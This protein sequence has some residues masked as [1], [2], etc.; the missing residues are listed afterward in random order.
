[1][2][3]FSNVA[4]LYPNF[5][6]SKVIRVA[7]KIYTVSLHHKFLIY[8]IMLNLFSIYALNLQQKL[9]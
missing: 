2:F 9:K 7:V 6:Q 4:T 1:M 3:L 8:I 5:E